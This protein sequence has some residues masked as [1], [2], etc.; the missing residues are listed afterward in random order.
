MIKNIT[1]LILISTIFG[2]NEMN[3]TENL[4]YKVEELKTENDSLKNII[5]TL[6]QKYIF[7]EV[8]VR[9]IP[10]NTNNYKLNSEYEAEIVVVGY[11]RRKDSIISFPEKECLVERMCNPYTL[12]YS[13]GGIQIK[14]KLD[15]NKNW[16][17]F[18]MSTEAKYGKKFER[19][20]SDLIKTK[21]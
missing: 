7:D 15:K 11:N 9:H 6:N 16:L 10:S 5:S 17:Q 19:T 8:T 2:C 3:R 21:N 20:V 1:L 12:T 14:T 4:L 18:K 13:N